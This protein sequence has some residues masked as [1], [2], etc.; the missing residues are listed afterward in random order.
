[1]ISN[2]HAEYNYNFPKIRPNLAKFTS[3]YIDN[4]ILLG[5]KLKA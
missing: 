2:I 4:V 1:M 5:Q 3:K